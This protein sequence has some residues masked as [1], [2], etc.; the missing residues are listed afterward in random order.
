MRPVEGP[1]FKDEVMAVLD[2]ARFLRQQTPATRPALFAEFG[3]AKDDWQ[4]SLFLRQDT[5]CVHLH[6]A[7]WASALSGLAGTV[8]SW[9]WED[10]D[11]LNAYR[12]YRALSTFMSDIPLTSGGLR[13]ISAQM[14][15]NRWRVVGLQSDKQA[16]LWVSD[17]EST[18]WKQV[19]EKQ[20]PESREVTFS[21]AGLDA[22]RYEVQW[23]NTLEGGQIKTETLIHSGPL[24]Q[25]RTPTFAS[26]IAAKVRPL[27]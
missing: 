11:R 9:W 16:Y 8:H 13:E 19:V 24:L 2:R 17:S 15:D 5:N 22:A 10:L 14:S 6:N 4:P 20:T 12:H 21:I 3:L 1:K 23:W 25:L 27:R 7:L 18:W 26:D